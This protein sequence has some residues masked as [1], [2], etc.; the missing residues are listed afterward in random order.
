MGQ[1]YINHDFNNLEMNDIILQF[2]LNYEFCKDVKKSPIGKYSVNQILERIENIINYIES[3][4]DILKHIMNEYLENNRG[5]LWLYYGIKYGTSYIDNNWYENISKDYLITTWPFLYDRD[6]L[7]YKGYQTDLFQAQ[8]ELKRQRDRQSTLNPSFTPFHPDGCSSSC[9]CWMLDDMEQWYK[10]EQEEIKSSHNIFFNKNLQDEFYKEALLELDNLK[11]EW[12]NWQP[13]H[14]SK[15]NDSKKESKEIMGLTPIKILINW[16]DSDFG[17][18]SV[19]SIFDWIDS[20]IELW[21][22]IDLIDEFVKCQR[23]KLKNFNELIN[24]NGV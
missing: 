23:E 8:G 2:K 5:K 24:S 15:S 7:I 17:Y 3:K 14:K 16:I 1:L 20:F 6:N 19:L 13:L 18:S 4:K 21:N 11:S 10:E 9:C 12:I 22:K